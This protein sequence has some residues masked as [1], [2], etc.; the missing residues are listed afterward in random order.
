MMPGFFFPVEQKANELMAANSSLLQD[1]AM[2]AAKIY[3]TGLATR[4]AF[5][6][7]GV[8]WAGFAQF[9]FVR[10]PESVK[11]VQRDVNIFSKGFN[12]LKKVWNQVQDR[13]VIKLY[14]VGFFFTSMGVQ[15]VM[16]V[17]SLFGEEELKLDTAKLI[18][19]VLIIQLVAIGGAWSFSKLS[20]RIGNIYTLLIM[21]C[22]WVAI[23]IFAYFVKT[24]YQFYALA[25]VVGTVM[26]GVQSM[27]R[28]TFAKIIPD[29]TPDPASFF[30][31]YDVCEKIAAVVGT[32][33]FGF[34]NG[35]TGNMRASILALIVYFIVGLFFISRI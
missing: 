6:S 27:L 22:T 1:D 2:S 11:P 26:G 19:T 28:S 12:E 16:Y 10:V 35:M 4:L 13:P 21:V 32:F 29:D 17:A 18:A 23:C 5:V 30:S 8:W 14:L 24:D 3:Y 33:S 7:V 15:T 31:F 9:L 25:F 20:N 34:I